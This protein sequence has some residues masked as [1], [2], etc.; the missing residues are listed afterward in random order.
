MG[1]QG[2]KSLRGGSMK[3]VIFA[4]SECWFG[5]RAQRAP[6]GRAKVTPT[7]D[8]SDALSAFPLTGCR[9][10]APCSAQV[11]ASTRLTVPRRV[12]PILRTRSRRRVWVSRWSCSSGRQLDGFCTLPP[13]SAAMIEQAAGWSSTA[14][15][16]EDQPQ[17][18]VWARNVH[19]PERPGGELDCAAAAAERATR[20]RASLQAHPPAGGTLAR[21]LGVLQ[22]EA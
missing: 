10:R 21:Q 4:G 15:A 9:F 12:L 5:R 20:D 1:E 13:S 14:A 6:L 17:A 16:R 19:P 3:D 7:L 2:A 11:A 22:A 8:N 18:G